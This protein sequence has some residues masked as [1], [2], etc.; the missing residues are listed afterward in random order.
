MDLGRDGN[1]NWIQHRRHPHDR[2]VKT[3][4][5]SSKVTE[6]ERKLYAF[7]KL[8]DRIHNMLSQVHLD[9]FSAPL[10]EAGCSV[11][12]DIFPGWLDLTKK[13]DHLYFTRSI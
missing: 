5:R 11:L 8:I 13:D 1:L 9:K 4:R 6:P 12:S 7:H 3:P 10:L 2:G